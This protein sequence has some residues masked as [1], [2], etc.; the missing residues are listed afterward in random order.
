VLKVE[1]R[2]RALQGVSQLILE[3]VALPS[4]IRDPFSG[5]LQIFQQTGKYSPSHT[6][7]SYDFHCRSICAV[8]LIGFVRPLPEVWG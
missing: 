7:L 1:N 3:V 2:Q 6:L 8:Y 4:F 5:C